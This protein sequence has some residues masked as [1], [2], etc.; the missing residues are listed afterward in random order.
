MF[1]DAIRHGAAA[2]DAFTGR[3]VDT[4]LAAQGLRRE[5]ML[6]VLASFQPTTEAEIRATACSTL[7]LMG[8]DDH[9]NGS[10]ETLAEWV[11]DGRAQRTPGDHGTTVSTPEFREALVAFLTG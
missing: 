4:L 5:A 10:A 6:G 1:E 8:V 9:D 7:A 11:A 3:A 2:K